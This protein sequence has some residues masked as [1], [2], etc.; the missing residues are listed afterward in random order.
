MW[1]APTERVEGHLIPIAGPRGGVA[2]PFPAVKG[3]RPVDTVSRRVALELE[4]IG[5]SPG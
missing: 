2:L 4:L 1:P 5:G 3:Y